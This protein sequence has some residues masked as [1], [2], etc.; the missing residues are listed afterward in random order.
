MPHGHWNLVIAL[1]LAPPW[2]CAFG[3]EATATDAT[4]QVPLDRLQVQE[5]QQNS[6][7]IGFG[8]FWMASNGRLTKLDASS[9]ASST[10]VLDASEGPCRDIGIGEGAVWV[11]DCG[12]GV[13][14]K[15][16]PLTGKLL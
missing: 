8:A 6:D 13:I 12:K 10:I 11:P 9:G 5:L 15:V 4:E 14:Y 7:T 2:C 3:L 16:D 1:L